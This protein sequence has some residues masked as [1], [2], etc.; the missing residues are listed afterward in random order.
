[1]SDI[2][3]PGDPVDAA[4]LDK[5]F[6]TMGF[7]GA[8][9]KPAQPVYQM[10]GDTKI[11]V[12]KMRGK[13]WKHRKR[14]A[15]KAMEDVKGA[16]EEAKAYYDQDQSSM[17]EGSS[18][19]SS[20]RY[21]GR[22]LTDSAMMTENIVYSNIR[23]IVPNL[24]AKNP[25]L[26]AT[27]QPDRRPRT[28]DAEK[29]EDNNSNEQR[30]R[31]VAKLVNVLFAMKSKPGV[32]LKPLAKR[33][34]TL[35]LL[36]NLAWF[37]TGYTIK[38]ES[39][40]EAYKQ[41]EALSKEFAV[42]K[43]QTEIEE[44]EGKL[45]A[46]EEKIEFL[47]PGGPWVR[48]H[49]PSCVLVDTDAEDFLWLTD[50]NWI[51]IKGM[52][53]TAYVRA[54]YAKKLGKGDDGEWRSIYAPTHIVTGDSAADTEAYSIF[55]NSDSTSYGYGSDKDSFEKAKR[56]EVWYVW[57]RATRRVEMY[58][59]KDWTWPIW[60]WDDPL[61]LDTFF[62]VTPLFFHESPNNKYAKGPVSYYLSQQDELNAVN[63]EMARARQWAR[64]NIFY[65]ANLMD[66][67]DAEK[68]LTGAKDTITGLKVPDGMNP[69]D[70]VFSL[71]PPS[72]QFMQLFDKGPIY[73]AIDRIDA[74][75]E[76]QRGGQ[77]KT[78]TTNK[79]VDYYAT[80]GN[81]RNDERLDAVEDAIGDVGWKIAQLCLQFMKADQVTQMI[82]MDVT[83]FWK[84]INPLTDFDAKSIMCVGGSSQKLTGAAKKQ[85]AL[86]IAQILSQLSK[87]APGQVLKAVLDLFS[88]TF[89]SVVFT[90]EDWEAIE[91]EIVAQGQGQGAGPADPGDSG[92]P[93]PTS[94]A[95]DASMGAGN[96]QQIIL[97]VTKA[98]SQLPPEALKT[99]GAALAQG[100]PPEQIAQSI[101]SPQQPQ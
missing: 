83:E 27:A 36:T 98:L 90:K 91:E 59:A 64:R 41:L 65:N 43:S 2:I 7:D 56:T 69:K 12:S 61:K 100:V 9:N 11:P 47:L 60:V 24:Y 21:S 54:M 55:D 42:A 37:E 86:E 77:F 87:T 99:I 72:M 6:Q 38:G 29:G 49:D 88:T 70:M 71:T 19:N 20:A 66:R 94:G 16:W 46:L 75:N 3:P 26:T 82:N 53:P 76:A 35:A 62:P 52:L 89:D 101:L 44:I 78:N 95:P 51:M 81:S 73:S 97:L 39:S 50:A 67:V 79:A 1:M 32:H 40:E 63:D 31:A 74:T 68:I 22:R 13:L 8:S 5:A 30:A 34:I 25:V 4:P 84:A 57:D 23:G 28:S 93:V 48:L 10:V 45:L 14:I 17:R 58:N 33:A 80:M 96:P 92:S 15:E 18:R 85:E